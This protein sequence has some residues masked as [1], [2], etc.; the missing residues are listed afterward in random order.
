MNKK[1][2]EWFKRKVLQT[3]GYNSRL[4]SR[5]NYFKYIS[6]NSEAHEDKKYKVFK[7]LVKQGKEVLTEV[8]F[9]KPW[10]GRCDILDV[11]TG[12]IFEIVHTETKESLE[13]KKKKYPN[14][15]NFT[16]VKTN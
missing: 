14:F 1:K 2:R 16:V 4:G 9:A 3:V 6:S 8:E 10:E 11:S 7:K 15:L 5:I 13:L 12:E